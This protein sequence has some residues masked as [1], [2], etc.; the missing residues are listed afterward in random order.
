MIRFSRLPAA[1]FLLALLI[2]FVPGC[3]AEMPELS[4]TAPPETMPLETEVRETEVLATAAP[5]Y[6]NASLSVEARVADLL[7]RMT[8]PEKI[9][10]MAQVS[11]GIV[12][13]GDVA[14]Y[15]LGSILSGGGGS[16][17]EN[18]VEGW[19]AMVDGYQA[20]AL[21]TRLQ[22]PILYGVDAVHGHGNLIGATVFPHQI[23]LG[24]TRNPELVEQIAQATAEE[25]RATG[26][27]W[28]FAPVLAAAQDIRWGRTYESFSE[29]PGVVD[30]LGLAY[31][32]GLQM[33]PEGYS[34]AA[35]QTIYVLATPKHFLGDGGT[36]WGTSTTGSYQIDQGDMQMDEVAVRELFLKP[37]QTVVNAGAMAIMPSYSSWN[38]TKMHAST[39]WLTDVLRGELGFQGLVISD[40][41]ALNQIDADYYTAIVTGI[42]AGVDM[43]MISSDFKGFLSVMDKAVANGDI[44]IERIDEAVRRILTVKFQLGLFE[45]PYTAPNLADVVGSEEHRQIARQ[46]VRESLVLLK[47]EDQVLPLSEELPVLQVSGA[48]AN[49][50]GVQSGGWTITWQGIFGNIQPGTTILDGIRESVSSETIVDYRSDG[51]F[52]EH[53]E[54]GIV[55]VG[56]VPYAEGAGDRE[57]L[58]L[59]DSDRL[60]I[61][62]ARQTCDRLIVVILSG[63]PLIITEQYPLA[64]AWVAAWLPGTEGAGVAD[65]LFGDY[66]FTGK[67]PFTW[68]RSNDQIPINMHSV[69]E[70]A[71]Y[72]D[73]PLFPYGYGLGLAGSQP[74][75]WLKCP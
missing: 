41:N 23:G 44:S 73:M 16:P 32:R 56:E 72:C 45:N 9:G 51:S 12:R 58:R 63:R 46:A 31:L 21:S 50:I 27:P 26:I 30:V 65:V 36:T 49:S 74:I 69:N 66:P 29:D 18:T 1:V 35:G 53:A 37:Y 7:D 24:A 57:D 25:V 71:A 67:L 55:V 13:E 48:K 28:N 64:E 3:S 40:F 75:E 4:E 43:N 54:V 59:S 34:P 6:L 19:A 11:K 10:Q 22:I 60:L 8:L 52:E 33:F 39:Y 17:L 20:E 14:E 38:G 2:I 70:E 15:L 47:N 5:A 68:P 62:T 42:N 61:E